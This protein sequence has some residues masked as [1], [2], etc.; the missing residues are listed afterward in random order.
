LLK[1]HDYSII[2][3]KTIPSIMNFNRYSSLALLGL[4]LL[5][6]PKNIYAQSPGGVTGSNTIWLKA[7]T[8]VTLGPTNTVTTWAE[9]S[10]SA[11]TGDFSTQGAAINK[12][13]HQAPT[14]LANGL[15][16]N[17]YIVFNNTATP[18]SIS[19]GNAVTG[20]QILDGTF[21][22][23]FQ[24][25]KLH[26]IPNTGVWVKWQ[27]ATTPYSGPRLG[28][29]LNNSNLGCVRFD[30]RTNAGSFYS[31]TNI[32]EKNALV[33]QEAATTLKTIRLT[34]AQD[35]STAVSGTFTPGTTTG[36]IT[37][38]AEPYGDDYPTK[39]DIAEF[40]LYKRA[41]TALERNQVESY[42]AV[43][44]GMTLVQT[45]IYANDYTASNGTV[46]WNR[47]ANTTFINNI[48]GVG[49][50]DASGLNQKQSL[51]INN[52]AMVTMYHGN[53][54]GVFP[55][56]NAD[57]TFDFNT[58]L[59]YV[60]FGDNLADTL[61][62]QCSADGKFS[63]MARTWKVQVT[64]TPGDVTLTL[65][66][67]NVPPAITSLIVASD[68]NFTTGVVHIPIQD[69]GTELYASYNFT[70]NQYFT[71]GSTP[72][73]L[74]GVVGPVLCS[75]NN[76]TVTLNPTG[77]VSPI[78]YSWNTTPIQTG[79]NLSG[80]GPGNYTVTVTQDNGCSFSESYTVTGNATPIYVKVKDTANTICTTNNGMIEVYGI[81]G[82]PSYSYNIDGGPFASQKTF[83]GLATGAHVIR[84]K[85]QNNCESDT[86]VVLKN[87]SYD[88]DVSA[89][90]KNAWC[91]AAGLG[92]EVSI[93]ALGGTTPYG[94]F[95]ENLPT[96]K[97]PE[98]QNLP[99]GNYKV[100][101]TDK[102]GCT[103]DAT[104]LVEEN[105]CCSIWIPNA[106]SPNADGKNDKFVSIA[107]RPI[108]KYEMSI[109]NRWGQRVFYTTRY[110][111]GWD[112]THNN[113][114]TPLDVGN[115]YY[116]IKYTCEM[117]KKEMVYQGD[118]TLIR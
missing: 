50:D 43:K 21:C 68:P 20:T 42:L 64:G 80:V 110:A 55:A 52:R 27:W 71:F 2:F 16:F 84:V 26:T 32:F 53:V 65:Q 19:S 3:V 90:A 108:P 95:W 76:G 29:E 23:M 79:Q 92:G 97:G 58:D 24:V 107:N 18:N 14:F 61:V 88:L 73:A 75:G 36:R 72:L 44:Y 112:G 8:G 48:T 59:S 40:I 118:V 113:D 60:L 10:G 9:Q 99:K 117:G 47:V 111:E 116:R 104:A 109:F 96:G 6:I 56:L 37:L 13:T 87:Y 89:T 38:G 49:R 70:N 81:G 83:N 91:D 34:G 35:A 41:L 54:P 7:N 17:P 115:Y 12:P 78:D 105:F 106:F 66:K 102:Y 67:A 30:F 57:N 93:T 86:T 31:A 94:Y 1:N 98:M 15:N 82:T 22:T 28:N 11:I 114:G 103:G 51:S 33:T 25:I 69:N 77:G 4:S 39:V 62:T 101:V 5:C 74:N 46:T 100:I 85:D 63:K 45:G